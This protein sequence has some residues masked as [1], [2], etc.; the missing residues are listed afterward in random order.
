[1]KLYQKIATL[2]LIK[3]DLAKELKIPRSATL[4][5]VGCL[6]FISGTPFIPLSKLKN[7]VHFVFSKYEMKIEI[8]DLQA[9]HFIGTAEHAKALFEAYGGRYWHDQV[10]AY[11]PWISVDLWESSI[12]EHDIWEEPTFDE[13]AAVSNASMLEKE[14]VLT[15]LL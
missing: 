6:F 14:E 11:N 3:E 12:H 13:Q 4:E 9:H 5:N 7:L 8:I 15:I 1:M 2:A 10:F